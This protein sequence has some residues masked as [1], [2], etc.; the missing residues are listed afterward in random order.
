MTLYRQ[1]K[2]NLAKSI[3]IAWQAVQ[4]TGFTAV[5]GNGYPCN[6]TSGEFTA[7][8]PAS[9]SVGDTVH[10]KDYAGTFASNPLTI[11]RNSSNM[12][13]VASD[14]GLFTNKASA[15]LVYIDATKGWLYTQQ[16]N[17]SI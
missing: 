5:A 7:T 15:T 14:N 6:T 11:G 17:V 1:E 3:S 4:T 13:G 10:L 8:L 2:Y 12:Q 16:S 9:P